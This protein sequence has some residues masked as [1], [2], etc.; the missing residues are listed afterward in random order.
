MP[1]DV[2][3][4]AGLRG[5]LRRTSVKEAWRVAGWYTADDLYQDGFICY[6]KCRDRYTLALPAPGDRPD[7][8]AY[9]NLFTD[10][11]NAQQRRHFM[12]LVQRTF[13]NHL[14][15]L[16]SR[17]PT[18]REQPLASLS[19][20]ETDEPLSL[21]ELL[22]PEPEEISALVALLHAPT[23]IADAVVKLVNDGI[24]G[25][26][27]LRSRLRVSQDGRV[28]LGKRSLRET[29]D[30]RMARVVGDPELAGKTMT[31]I[32]S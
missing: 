24:D 23:E 14:Y 29:T 3:F 17:Y 13:Y 32:L 6:C 8:Y 11:P 7:G 10:T 21:E 9:Q 27:Y 18:T 20:G 12:N 2:Y 28:T 1:K 22:P 5:W 26:K 25:G 15:T 4:D 19:K 30:Q 31:Y 16:A